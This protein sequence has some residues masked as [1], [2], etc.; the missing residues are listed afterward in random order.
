MNGAKQFEQLLI[1][2]AQPSYLLS[3]QACCFDFDLLKFT[4]SPIPDG[5]KYCLESSHKPVYSGYWLP[6]R[7]KWSEISYVQW[8][9]SAGLRSND[10]LFAHNVCLEDDW[11]AKYYNFGL[12]L[13]WQATREFMMENNILSFPRGGEKLPEWEHSHWI[14]QSIQRA[15]S[16]CI[17]DTSPCSVYTT[18]C[19]KKN[20][21][22]EIYL[23]TS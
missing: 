8:T 14:S 11:T 16:G 13:R 17:L 18:G 20:Y 23:R 10:P 12:R 9:P 5:K 7:Q 1:F 3:C 22:S 19:P 15:T 4:A 21:P 6:G 2:F